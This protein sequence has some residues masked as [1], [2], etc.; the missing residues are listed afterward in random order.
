MMHQILNLN[1][2]LVRKSLQS[3]KRVELKQSDK[4]KS[5][6]K[7]GKLSKLDKEIRL[8]QLYLQVLLE[9]QLTQMKIGIHLLNIRSW[10]TLNT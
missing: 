9:T 7:Y 6:K 5:K 2:F 10:V 1:D 3:L 4:L 8:A